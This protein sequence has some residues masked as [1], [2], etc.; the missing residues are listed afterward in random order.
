MPNTA[1]IIVITDQRVTFF[2][3]EIALLFHPHAGQVVALLEISLP[4]SGHF[5][6]ATLNS[7]QQSN[8]RLEGIL[9]NPWKKYSFQLADCYMPIWIRTTQQRCP[10]LLLLLLIVEH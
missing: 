9:V 1:I 5:I 8:W 2:L 4:H 7:F 10:N 3:A 6:K